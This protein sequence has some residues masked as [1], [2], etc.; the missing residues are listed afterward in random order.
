MSQ[1]IDGDKIISRYY[2]TM[3]MC[4]KVSLGMALIGQTPFLVAPV[5][6]AIFGSSIVTWTLVTVKA[7]KEYDTNH[8]T[9]YAKDPAVLKALA[10]TVSTGSILTTTLV[11]KV[12]VNQING[13]VSYGA[14]AKPSI[15][16]TIAYLFYTFKFTEERRGRN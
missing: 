15:V 10:I 1:G 14:L 7:L 12:M 2:D 6:G 9:E 13:K 5:Q 11:L 8:S 4:I 16:N 3:Q